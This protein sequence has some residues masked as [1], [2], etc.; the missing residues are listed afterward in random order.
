MN[1]GPLLYTHKGEDLAGDW[2]S[3]IIAALQQFLTIA[4]N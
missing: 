2:R 3:F 1:P 4:I